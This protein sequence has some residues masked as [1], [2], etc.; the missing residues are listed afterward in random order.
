MSR[1]KNLIHP[2][3]ILLE[4]F[5]RPKGISQNKLAMEIRV[6]TPRINA[7]V[8]GNRAITADTAIRLAKFFGTSSEFW[9]N[10][11]TNY[12]LALAESEISE[13]VKKIPALV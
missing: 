1:K 6:A 8:H 11:Q 9:M 12:D 2:G 10:L 4:E 7:I 5:L 3:E 13:E